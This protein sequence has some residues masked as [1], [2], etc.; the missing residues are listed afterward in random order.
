V[1]LPQVSALAAFWRHTPPAA[2]Q[3]RRIA[4][5]LGLQPLESA[6]PGAALSPEQAMEAAQSAG[7]AVAH[8]R[9]DDPL[10][11]FLDL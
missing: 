1:T 11:E 9:P 3:L 6:T 10:L 5:F 2:L 7:L 8:G 4:L